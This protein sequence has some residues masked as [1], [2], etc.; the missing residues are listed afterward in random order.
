MRDLVGQSIVLTT[1]LNVGLNIGVVTYQTL[2]EGLR[3]FKL[4][5]LARKQRKLIAK[6]RERKIRQI[7]RFER[8]QKSRRKQKNLSPALEVKELA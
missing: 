8:Q 3:K 1:F 2:F 5:R 6:R 7:L 4:W